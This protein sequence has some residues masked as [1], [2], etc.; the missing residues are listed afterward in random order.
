MQEQL[1]DIFNVIKQEFSRNKIKNDN[2]EYQAIEVPVTVAGSTVTIDAKTR[3]EH[4]KILGVFTYLSGGDKNNY[5][6]KIKIEVDGKTIISPEY[7]HF[8][9]IEKTDTIATVDTCFRVLKEI[10]NSTVK[11]YLT[12]GSTV[13][14]PY[15]AYIYFILEK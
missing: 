14:P 8:S 3:I 10:H 4:K 15:S 12:D 1:L 5:K 6:T 2:L 7:F 11:V 9:L 13:T